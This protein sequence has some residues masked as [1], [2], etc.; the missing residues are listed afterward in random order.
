MTLMPT[1]KAVSAVSD[2]LL[3]ILEPLIKR[4]PL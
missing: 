1:L 4:R 2:R 3:Y